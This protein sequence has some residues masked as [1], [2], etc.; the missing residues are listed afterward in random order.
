MWL[1]E[2]T[3][4]SDA[5]EFIRINADLNR[6]NPNYIRPLDQDVREVFDPE[7]NKAFR[8]GEAIRWILKNEEGRGV[9]RIAAFVNKKYKTKGDE[10][11]V[12]GIG[13]FD[14]INNQLSADMLFDVAKDWLIQKGMGAMDGPI[15][16]GERD[17]WWGLVTEG[18]DEPLYGMS[19]NPPYYKDLFEQYGFRVF[20]HQIC[21]FYFV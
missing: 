6:N 8:H 12:G 4:E 1:H 2:V 21:F 10:V 11:P 7:K 16:F 20:F 14:C 18:Y 9:G 13:F 15:N 5:N 19:F 3:T 17:K